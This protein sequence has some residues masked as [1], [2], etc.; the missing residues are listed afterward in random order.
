MYKCSDKN[1]IFKLEELRDIFLHDFLWK[2]QLEDE[3]YYYVVI[4]GDD[5]E[6]IDSM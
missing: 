3:L 4:N 1:T 5:T 2:K 6:N